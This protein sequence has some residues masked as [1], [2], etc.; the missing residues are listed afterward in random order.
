MSFLCLVRNVKP[1]Y[2]IIQKKKERKMS[3][4]KSGKTLLRLESW[5]ILAQNANIWKFALE[6]FKNKWQI[7]NQYIQNRVHRK[8]CEVKKVNVFWPLAWNLKNKSQYKIPDFPNFE[9][10]CC[11]ELFAIFWVVFAGFESFQLV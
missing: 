4:L 3:D 6:I 7:Q 11:F 1:K 5:Y 8:F 9:N 10:L 2:K